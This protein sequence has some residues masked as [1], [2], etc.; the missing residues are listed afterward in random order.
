M[1]VLP[2]GA[3][4]TRQPVAQ[5]RLADRPEASEPL[6]VD[7][8]ELAWPLTLVA[9]RRLGRRPRQPRTAVPVEHLPDRRGWPTEQTGHDRRTGVRIRTRRKDLRLGF[10]REP[11][12]LP[13]RHRR[14]IQKRLPATLAITPPQTGS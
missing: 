14:P 5:D 2:A 4:T 12:R 3:G 1:K 8:D 11:P 7:V 10:R 9:V 6:D 13:L